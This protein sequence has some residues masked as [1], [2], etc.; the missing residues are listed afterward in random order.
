MRT[1]IPLEIE[2]KEMKE[3]KRTL[4]KKWLFV[5]KANP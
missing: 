5:T 3:A 2:G 4:P 1:P